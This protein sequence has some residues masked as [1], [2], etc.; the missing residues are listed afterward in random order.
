MTVLL[1]GS[2]MLFSTFRFA[3]SIL[4][5]L[6]SL[7]VV[8]P[9]SQIVLW[10]VV[11]LV[12]EFGHWFSLASLG[13][14]IWEFVA[15]RR[16]SNLGTV[17][18]CLASIAFFL[19]P[20]VQATIIAGKLPG[21]LAA[22]F[23]EKNR[24]SFPAA[25]L[26]YAKLWALTTTPVAR[27]QARQ[28][29]SAGSSL[30]LRIYKNNESGPRP[31]ILIIHGGGWN[32]GDETQLPERSRQLAAMG[33]RVASMAYRLAPRFRW[34]AQ[35]E[36]VAAALAYLKAHAAEL[37]IDP[38]R[39]ILLGRSA[40]GQIALDAAYAL[41]DPAI[42]GCIASY[43]P[44]DMNFAY[45]TGGENDIL[46]SRKLVRGIM[47]GPPAS[48]PDLYRDASPLDFVGPDTPPTLLIHG[49][50]DE[51]VWVRHS[52][53]LRERM[54]HAG[55]PCFLLE[56]PWATHGFDVTSRGPGAQLELYAMAWFLK[57]L[58]P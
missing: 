20:V 19:T 21:Q 38:H 30:A 50:R 7:M 15:Q 49:T 33:Y 52:E 17:I 56:L 27:D 9:A 12:T 42:L 3:S 37:G 53:R 24:P 29:T 6:L 55:R 44:T 51:I 8:V 16:H 5:F 47:G 31:C 48:A 23:G 58:A 1:I 34:P 35:K 40:G 32:S 39:F 10:Y 2:V 13:I 26:S 36:D 14:L 4:L 18:L 28:F 11:I 43:P 46:G 45:W 54:L 41:R 22:I 57:S 25:P